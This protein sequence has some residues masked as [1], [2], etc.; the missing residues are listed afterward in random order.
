MTKSGE[1]SYNIVADATVVTATKLLCRVAAKEE[2]DMTDLIKNIGQIWRCGNLYRTARY[3]ALG[4]GS[5]QDSYIV[6]VCTHP[7]ITQEALSKLIFVHK[8]NVARQLGS[9]EEKGYVTRK[10]DDNDKRN[11]LV[12][13]TARAF[14]A[15]REIER[16]NDEW[17]SLVLGGLTDE[18]RKAAEKLIGKLAENAG[19][20]IE[21]EYK[22]EAE[23]K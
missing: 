17:D 19:R 2:K 7:G 1:P 3:D 13:P 11:L 20:L 8:S 5:Y 15:L 18:E 23:T 21:K 12:Y 22:K 14:E 4:I 16:V 6:N 9:L 10:T